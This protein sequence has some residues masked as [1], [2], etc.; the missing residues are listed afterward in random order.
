MNAVKIH[1]L[2][3]VLVTQAAALYD[4]AVPYFPIEI[5]RTA[6]SSPR[7]SNALATG[8][9]TLILTL[10]Y[11]Q[12]LDSITFAMWLGLVILALVP[13]SK[14]WALHMF[15]VWIVFA[16]ACAHVYRRREDVSLLPPLV[17]ATAF[18][19][20]RI[21]LRTLVILNFDPKAQAAVLALTMRGERNVPKVLKVL[22]DRAMD[23][24]MRGPLALDEDHRTEVWNR[25]GPA[26]KLCGVL[27]W[28]S[29]ISLSFV[30]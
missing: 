28:V 17:Y 27:Q 13:D 14:N 11:T 1:L 12:T 29:F 7:A 30:L 21:A 10:F 25:I 6:A 9:C 24:M 20:F 16:A 19:L 5:S 15:G 3:T 8:F 18:Y 2:S 23:V 22:F 26:F 4:G